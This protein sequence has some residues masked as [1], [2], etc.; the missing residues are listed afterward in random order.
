MLEKNPYDTVQMS[1]SLDWALKL[2]NTWAQPAQL[3][4]IL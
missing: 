4:G 3:Q 1:P 2:N